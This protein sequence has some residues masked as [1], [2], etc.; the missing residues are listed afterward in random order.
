M[1]G[2]MSLFSHFTP[3]LSPRWADYSDLTL[4]W[5]VPGLAFGP[6]IGLFVTGTI[7]LLLF[8]MVDRFTLAWTRKKQ[9]AF[10]III[11]AGLSMTGLS[12]S[13][14]I[15]MWLASGLT[16]GFL[17]WIAYVLVLRH[18]LSLAL[19][20]S[21]PMLWISFLRGAIVDAYPGARAGNLL[22]M[23]VMP[24]LVYLWEK[25]LRTERQAE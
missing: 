13:E 20:L 24:A 16:K 10:L 12:T 18:S 25:W 22:A 9:A 7:Y 14:S 6:V 21:V 15:G 17:L 19:W 5:P 23:L 4:R 3:S 8:V 2:V 1:A 11:L